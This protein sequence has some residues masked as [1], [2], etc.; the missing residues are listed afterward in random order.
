MAQP[1]G[2]RLVTGLL[3]TLGA[4][5]GME[6]QPEA[7][8]LAQSLI[9]LLGLGLMFWGTIAV[10]RQTRATPHTSLTVRL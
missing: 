9:A 6:H 10:N 5:G 4:V 7:S 2:I 3:L 1:G 8:L